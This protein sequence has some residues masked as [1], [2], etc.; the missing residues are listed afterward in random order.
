[1]INT[2]NLSVEPDQA[3]LCHEGATTDAIV[4][5]TLIYEVALNCLRCCD[6][7][8]TDPTQTR[9]ADFRSSM[10]SYFPK[11]VRCLGSRRDFDQQ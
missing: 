4:W 6:A 9:S 3:Q 5:M 7:V 1:M 10:T 8:K 11:Q 2:T